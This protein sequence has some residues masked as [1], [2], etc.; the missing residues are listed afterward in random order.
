MVVPSVS[1]VISRDHRHLLLLISIW[2]CVFLSIKNNTNVNNTDNSNTDNSWALLTIITMNVFETNRRLGIMMWT[3]SLKN[4][5]F[6]LF[7]LQCKYDSHDRHSIV[8]TNK[9]DQQ[10]FS[11]LGFEEFKII[12]LADS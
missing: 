7:F 3:I 2:H 12:H 1:N 6:T 8:F 11:H 4:I 9:Y 5:C 10:I